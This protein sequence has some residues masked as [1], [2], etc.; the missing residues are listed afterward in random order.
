[1]WIAFKKQKY[2]MGGKPT[3]NYFDQVW[4]RGEPIRMA[5][6]KAGIQYNDNLISNNQWLLFKADKV[7]CPKG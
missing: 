1:M 4:A 5:L 3:L 2:L 6:W 7:K